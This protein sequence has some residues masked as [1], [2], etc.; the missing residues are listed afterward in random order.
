[1]P[2]L[3]RT[4]EP[5]NLEAV[6]LRSQSSL[7]PQNSGSEVLKCRSS[8]VLTILGAKAPRIPGATAL[9]SLGADDPRS[10]GSEVLKCRSSSV[11]TI[12][13]AD[14]PRC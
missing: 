13:G 10:H 9:R 4:T 11:L 1:M 7:V 5:R 14:D 8:S 2:K 6:A 3:C 12:L